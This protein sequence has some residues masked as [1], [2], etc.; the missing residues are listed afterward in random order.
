MAKSRHAAAEIGARLALL[1]ASQPF[2][3]ALELAGMGRRPGN[4]RRRGT[5]HPRTVTAAGR[6]RCVAGIALNAQEQQKHP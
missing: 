4:L 2:N 1:A 3:R 5:G 6:D